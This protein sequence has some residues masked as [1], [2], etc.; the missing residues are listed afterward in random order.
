MYVIQ[1]KYSYHTYGPFHSYES[2]YE[3]ISYNLD[4]DDYVIIEIKN[5]SELERAYRYSC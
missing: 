1:E 3:F 5:P 4:E 2:A